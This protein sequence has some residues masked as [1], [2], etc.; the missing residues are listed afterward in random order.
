M[1]LDLWKVLKDTYCHMFFYN[2]FNTLIQKFHDNGLYAHGTARSDRINMLQM[3]KDK[4]IKRGV[5]QCKFYNQIVCIKWYDNK[6][7]MLLGSHLEEITS[8]STMQRSLE[9]PSSTIPVNFPSGI[10][11]YNR[12]MEKS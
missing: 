11:L 5:Y 2:F 3:K 12:K 7:V 1:V 8:I 4:E 10:M 6:S 9:G